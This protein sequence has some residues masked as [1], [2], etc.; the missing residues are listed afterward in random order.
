MNTELKQHIPF[1]QYQLVEVVFGAAHVDVDV[2]HK[3]FP[4]TPE[5]IFYTPVSGAQAGTVY[6][7]MSGTRAAW[8]EGVI[9]LRCNVAQARVVLLLWVAHERPNLIQA[10]P[11]AIDPQ[12]PPIAHTHAAGD[13]ASGTL[14]LAR[15]PTITDAKL[16][17]VAAPRLTGTID[18]AR[19][20]D[21][22][23][24]VSAAN[25]THILPA[26]VVTQF[27]GASAP[28]GW[29]LCD[30]ASLLRSSYPDL[31]S[32]IGTTWGSADATHFNVPDLRGRAVI[33]AGAGA[34]LTARALGDTLGAET[35]AL[36]TGDMPAHSHPGSSAT[37]TISP[38]PHN[39]LLDITNTQAGTGVAR[40][41]PEV[42]DAGAQTYSTRDT[43]LTASTSVTVASEGSGAAHNN[44][45]PSAAVN[46]I[47]KV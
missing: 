37:T 25:L 23:P 44:M 46:Y 41:R 27:A 47:I 17:T 2:P 9:R 21:P 40:P 42:Q 38:N 39:H 24:A 4:P 12:T 10:A 18:G 33:G 5:H 45:Q 11:A 31:F 19:I 26:G 6:H 16:D 13:V 14:D 15:I 32:A 8:R 34:G 22:L 28:T 7:D 1:A 30:G 20:P 29:L 36:A 43:T 3:L 35:V